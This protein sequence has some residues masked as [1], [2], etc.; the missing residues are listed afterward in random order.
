MAV[1]MQ[2]WFA[3]RQLYWIAPGTDMAANRAWIF[4]HPLH[5]LMMLFVNIVFLVLVVWREWLAWLLPPLAAILVTRWRA[6]K[7]AVATACTAAF[8][9]LALTWTPGLDMRGWHTILP[10][11][12]ERYLWPLLP[13]LAIDM[14]AA[15]N[16]QELGQGNPRSL[17]DLRHQPL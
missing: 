14:D 8:L 13:L 16:A 2:L 11:F 9:S 15:D 5:T 17:K 3:E 10:G 1:P 12:Q 7:R 6:D 4:A